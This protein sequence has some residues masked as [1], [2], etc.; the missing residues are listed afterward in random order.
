MTVCIRS[1]ARQCKTV[2]P[3]KMEISAG[4]FNL[5]Y[6]YFMGNPCVKRHYVL[7][8][9]TSPVTSLQT[10]ESAAHWLAPTYYTRY[11]NVV[12]TDEQ[13]AC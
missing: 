12:S 7:P 3:T 1:G 4:C 6:S 11:E 8:H 13:D 10:Y 2:T 9:F 5:S